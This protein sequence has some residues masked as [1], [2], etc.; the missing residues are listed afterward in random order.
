MDFYIS[1][2]KKGPIT[3][4]WKHYINKQFKAY[5][6]DNDETYD[7]ESEG[8]RSSCDCEAS[9]LS[10]IIFA[11]LFY[12]NKFNAKISYDRY[13]TIQDYKFHFD[14]MNNPK[15]E[16][17]QN[18]KQ[19]RIGAIASHVFG[20][21]DLMKKWEMRYHRIGNFA[22]IPWMKVDNSK[23][24]QTL[25]EGKYYERWDM[26]LTYL[27]EKWDEKIPF[28]FNEYM[29]ST[30]QIIYYEEVL[31]DYKKNKNI[32]TDIVKWYKEQS[33]KYLNDE[34]DNIKFN[35]INFNG[36]S[37]KVRVDDGK[38]KEAIENINLLIDL[39]G[40]IILGILLNIEKRMV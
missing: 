25:H 39:R 10:Q 13:I 20:C 16:N 8:A 12:E 34:N 7:F 32:I 18:N 37:D 24:M 17:K 40:K 30:C 27:Q 23:N 3:D 31:Q 15:F 1:Q 29:V 21:N 11:T 35:I 14:V 4:E 9:Y 6:K 28:T 36:D 2:K 38:I 33:V 19:N 26:L 5:I 22:P